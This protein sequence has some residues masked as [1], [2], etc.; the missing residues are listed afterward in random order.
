MKTNLN[1]IKDELLQFKNSWMY[2]ELTENPDNKM[3]L[4]VHFTKEQFDE[5]L[6]I[7]EK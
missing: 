7:L 3:G 5:L 2:E 6:K 4:M 1:S